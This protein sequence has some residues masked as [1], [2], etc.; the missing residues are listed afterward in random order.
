MNKI[1]IG[2]V[3]L[4]LLF[5]LFSCSSTQ[6]IK[7]PPA[8]RFV[9]ITL[10]KAVEAQTSIA[11]PKNPTTIFSPRDPEVVAFLKLENLWGV[12]TLKWDWFDPGGNLYYSTGDYIIESSPGKYLKEVTTWHKLS[13]RGEEAG[14]LIGDWTLNVFLD[15]EVVALRNFKIDM[16]VEELPEITHRPNPKYWGLVISIENYHEL[17]SVN[18]AQKDALLIK[19]YFIKIL[20]VPEANIIYL[21]NSEATKARIMYNLR[22]YIPRNTENNS[23]LYVYF[24][25]HGGLDEGKEGPYIIPYD[26]NVRFSEDTSY[27]LKDFYEDLENLQIRR[28][29]VFL[30]TSFNGIAPR[31]DNLILPGAKR[32]LKPT[33]N[34][35]LSSDKVISMISATEGQVSNAYPEKGYGLFTYFLLRGLRGEAHKSRSG[36]MT[37]GELYSYVRDQV[38][39]VSSRRGIEQIPILTPD[40]DK[41]KD[42][43]IE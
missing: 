2:F 15:K 36:L 12:H 3:F 21:V 35:N 20:G 18:Y 17:P 11:V 25:G 32:A 37:L 30:D 16:E 1:K 14:K 27:R 13:I 23:L 28:S 39:K 22:T 9:D 10:S 26:G 8:F 24:V 29:F 5:F 43:E 33:G 4:I 7:R 41:V 31:S 38:M 19:Q 34:L 42:V 6:E 40:L